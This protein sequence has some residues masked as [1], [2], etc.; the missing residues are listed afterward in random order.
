[1]LAQA[2]HP[3]ALYRSLGGDMRQRHSVFTAIFSGKHRQFVTF[4]LIDPGDCPGNAQPVPISPCQMLLECSARQLRIVVGYPKT[5]FWGKP[6]EPPKIIFR[7]FERQPV[8]GRR[9]VQQP[10]GRAIQFAHPR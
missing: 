6:V 7:N 4:D 2:N 8:T 1:M 3:V 10:Y 5:E 9:G